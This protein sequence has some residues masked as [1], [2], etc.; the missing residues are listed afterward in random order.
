MAAA[1]PFLFPPPQQNKARHRKEP[2][3][4]RRRGDPLM[5]SSATIKAKT[6][7]RRGDPL[8]LCSA[9]LKDNTLNTCISLMGLCPKPH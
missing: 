2:T 7:N 6:K 8:M 1:P 9:Y 4:G 5:L 3:E